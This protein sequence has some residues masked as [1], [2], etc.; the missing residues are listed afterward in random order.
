MI[1]PIAR[2]AIKKTLLLTANAI[3]NK[4]AADKKAQQEA[5]TR[6]EEER[7]AADPNYREYKDAVRK[8]ER[9][10]A[11]KAR[12][13]EEIETRKQDR[14]EFVRRL[15]MHASFGMYIVC[16]M[17]RLHCAFHHFSC[18]FYD[19]PVENIL[20]PIW[21]LIVLMFAISD[22]V[23]AGNDSYGQYQGL[24]CGVVMLLPL[25]WLGYVLLEAIQI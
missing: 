20:P 8:R 7:E 2:W 16:V 6:K 19:I 18:H 24:G 14:R 5:E 13:A 21:M 10:A 15:L 4:I 12:I 3:D 22:F 9:V 11:E 17:Y 1:G 25:C 23:V